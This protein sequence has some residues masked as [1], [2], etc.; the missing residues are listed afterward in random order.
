MS[1]NFSSIKDTILCFE[2]VKSAF[3]GRLV[4]KFDVSLLNA[5][6]LQTDVF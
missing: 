1:V 2:I 3:K 5:Y 4:L 6:K